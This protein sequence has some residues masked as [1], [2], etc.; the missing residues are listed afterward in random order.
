MYRS[1]I[2]VKKNGLT[3]EIAITV[4]QIRFVTFAS[5]DDAKLA[6]DAVSTSTLDGKKIRVR[7]KSQ[8]KY[9]PT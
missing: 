5:E 3:F 7:L 1:F 9:T 8:T 2:P 4:H 6:I